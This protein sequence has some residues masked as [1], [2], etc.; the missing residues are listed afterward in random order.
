VGYP[1]KQGKWFVTAGNRFVSTLRGYPMQTGRSQVGY[2]VEEDN[3]EVSAL[4]GYPAMTGKSKVWVID[5]GS[6]IPTTAQGGN[7]GRQGYRVHIGVTR[8]GSASHI[9][10]TLS[11]RVTRMCVQGLVGSD[12]L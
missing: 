2:P 4:T 5:T 10:L 6:R 1:A 8:L 9:G 11:R 3:S 7:R 12:A